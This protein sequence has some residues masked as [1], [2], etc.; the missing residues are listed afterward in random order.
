MSSGLSEAVD[1]AAI[2]SYAKANGFTIV[3]KD[4][5]FEQRSVLYGHPP[6][7]IWIRLGNCTTSEIAVLL[8]SYQSSIVTFHSDDEK[9]YLP[10]P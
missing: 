5:D 1:D 7:V 9:S 10:L 6:K 2:W 3:T 4:D 8:S